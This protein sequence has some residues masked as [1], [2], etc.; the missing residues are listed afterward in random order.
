MGFSLG[1]LFDPAGITTGDAGDWINNML[2][3][4][5]GVAQN[6][7]WDTGAF[8]DWH[9]QTGDYFDSLNAFEMSQLS[10]WGE[11]FKRNPEQLLIG[12]GDPFS[13]KMW[14]GILGTDYQPYVNQY[15]GPT[16]E[17]YQSAEEKGVDT[18]N[19]QGSHQ[20]AQ[21]I[22]SYYG[23]EALGE[24]GQA[25]YASVAGDAVGGVSASSAGAAGGAFSGGVMGGANALNNDT[26]FWSGVGSG[27]LSGGLG[28]G[29]DYG[30]SLGMTDPTY[31]KLLNGAVT[32]G[33][34]AGLKNENIGKGLGKGL[35]GSAI[36]MA[37]QEGGTMLGDMFNQN[38]ESGVAYDPTAGGNFGGTAT[39]NPGETGYSPQAYTGSNNV[40]TDS[41]KA[42]GGI[43]EGGMSPTG[44]SSVGQ[45]P[46]PTSS[47]VSDFVSAFMGTG[48]GKSAGGG[49]GALASNLMGLYQANEQRKKMK[50]QMGSLNNLFTPSSPYAQHMRQALE[51]KDAAAGRRS[52]YG[53]R[54]A[55]MM[56]SLA[57]KQMQM[58]PQQ[59][60]MQKAVGGQ[61]N[62]MTLNGLQGLA[63]LYQQAPQIQQDWGSLM[64]MFGG[65]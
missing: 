52:Q 20:V 8:G 54:E 14:N 27:T 24:L 30:D 2:D 19:S 47:A 11:K 44:L 64:N 49:Y 41:F 26:D 61:Q 28:S 36:P 45:S 18:S 25:G 34:K 6:F 55:Q 29:F 59:M 58:A 22:A 53:P 50:E 17:S 16:K 3:P 23:G 31:K 7:G 32:G 57:E 51:R 65:R 48:G 4:A 21:A 5:G 46:A 40:G 56:A 42:L 37:A 43:T 62:A 39:A 33:V 12:A 1:K 15:G 10:D 63:R 13:A 38:K 35:A 60:A 9:Q